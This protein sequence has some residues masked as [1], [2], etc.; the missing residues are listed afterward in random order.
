MPTDC[1]NINAS[2]NSSKTSLYGSKNSM[3]FCLKTFTRSG[4]AQLL[5][6]E[7]QPAYSKAVFIAAAAD[8]RATSAFSTL[9]KT[10][11]AICS[12]A[13]SS[14]DTPDWAATCCAALKLTA[15]VDNAPPVVPDDT[16]VTA[17][18]VVA[19]ADAAFA[20]A[21]CAAVML[22]IAACNWAAVS[23]LCC[24]ICCC[25]CCICCCMAAICWLL[26]CAAAW[27]AATWALAVAAWA[28]AVASDTNWADMYSIN[29]FPYC[30]HVSFA[31]T[32][33]DTIGR[34]ISIVAH[35]PF[36][37]FGWAQRKIS[38]LQ[39]PKFA[40]GAD[41]AAPLLRG[42]IYE[43]H[44]ALL[45]A[46]IPELYAVRLLPAVVATGAAC[47]AGAINANAHNKN[48]GMYFIFSLWD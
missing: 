39:L 40:V 20:A 44:M 37:H 9:V 30:A 7:S 48:L 41:A 2:Y 36:A 14:A 11:P 46:P 8:R 31:R 15:P 23:A 12:R 29:S 43:F 4:P 17:D 5:P 35:P 19:G 25:I 28:A 16:L 1:A 22:S 45:S 10:W 6:V 42:F 26:C 34:A 33:P 47:V 32:H 27:A 38:A 13:S 3:A 18:V 24:C 21:V